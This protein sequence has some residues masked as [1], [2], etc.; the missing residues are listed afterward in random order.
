MGV[1]R[2]P[3]NGRAL[4]PRS[5]CAGPEGEEQGGGGMWPESALF[6]QHGDTSLLFEYCC[7]VLFSNTQWSRHLGLD[8]GLFH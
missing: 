7:V 5:D 8:L 3:L 2:V 6:S 4:L 1:V